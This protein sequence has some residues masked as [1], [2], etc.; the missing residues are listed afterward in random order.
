VDDNIERIMLLT[1]SKRNTKV[2]IRGN[3]P[4]TVIT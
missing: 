1:H 2:D 3:F 4:I